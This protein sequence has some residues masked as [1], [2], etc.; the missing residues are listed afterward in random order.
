MISLP[1]WEDDMPEG[2]QPSD[3]ERTRITWERSRFEVQLVHEHRLVSRE[4][5]HSFAKVA[6]Q[7]TFILNGGAL[8]SFPAFAKAV[9]TGLH[10]H[11][12][13]A[14]TSMVFF[15]IGLGLTTAATVLAFFAADA[16]ASAYALREMY[17]RGLLHKLAAVGEE[18]DFYGKQ[19]ESAESERRQRE[20]VWEALMLRAIGL[21]IASL[22][23]FVVGAFFAAFVVS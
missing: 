14:V 16:Y 15:V 10:D 4:H 2:N 11:V 18:K 9:G 20:D 8:I 23:A 22:A 1:R 3:P 6:I 12:G 5:A 17:V 21:V 7:S 19:A 13:L